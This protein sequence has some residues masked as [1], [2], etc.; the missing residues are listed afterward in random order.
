RS[1]LLLHTGELDEAR[2]AYRR[3]IESDRRLADA[4]LERSLDVAMASRESE[5]STGSS[6]QGKAPRGR[7][8]LAEGEGSGAATLTPEHPK[9]NFSDVGGMQAIK[10]EISIKIIEPLRNPELFRA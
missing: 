3:A 10:S 5:S 2:R 7:E 9:I 1:R 4:D 8:S 6:T